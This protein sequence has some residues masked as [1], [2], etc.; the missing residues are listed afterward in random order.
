MTLTNDSHDMFKTL[1]RVCW[2]DVVYMLDTHP[3]FKQM[4]GEGLLGNIVTQDEIIIESYEDAPTT[5]L[6]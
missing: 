5:K 3:A 2:G 6:S 1:R 4:R